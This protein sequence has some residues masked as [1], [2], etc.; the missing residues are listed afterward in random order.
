MIDV[1]HLAGAAP[2]AMI[3]MFALWAAASKR[4]W[5]LRTVVVAAVVLTTLLIPAYELAYQ[6]G[7]ESLLVVAGMAIWRRRRVRASDVATLQAPRRRFSLSL[8]TLMLTVVII[9]VATAV[10]AR[11]PK[12]KPHQW[13]DLLASGVM[14]AVICLTCVWL[15]CGMARWW[16][17]L[18]AAPFLVVALAVAM[19]FLKWGAWIVRH[20]ALSTTA[21]SDFWQGALGDAWQGIV[22]W[23]ISIGL[24]MAVLCTW[25]LLMRSA[26]WFDPF[27]GTIGASADSPIAKRRVALARWA[28][29]ILVCVVSLFPVAFFYR[30]LTPAPIPKVLLPVPNGFDDLVAAGR[31]IGAGAAAKLLAWDKLTQRQLVMELEKNAEAFNRMRRGFQK[32]SLHPYVFEPWRPEDAVALMHLYGALRGRTAFAR[33]SGNLD[34]ELANNL[35]LLRLAHAEK[36][37]IAT[38][39]NNGTIDAF[40]WDA[41]A[42]IWNLRNKLSA[43]QCKSLIA[44]LTELDRRREPWSVRVE[45]QRIIEQN[46][47][48]QD[49]AALIL[50]DWSGKEHNP[51]RIEHFRRVTELRIVTI[52][53]SLRAFQL[54][55]GRWPARLS[56]LVPDYLPGVPQDPFSNSEIKYRLAG[57]SYELYSIGPDEVDDGGKRAVIQNGMYVGDFTPLALF[58]PPVVVNQPATKNSRAESDP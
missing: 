17:R 38:R 35:D 14:L 13:Y 54:D 5:F 55:H 23:I 30:L 21:I 46:K 28:T 48:W 24:G 57:D 58:G 43:E 52:E 8:Q 56:E 49:H 42:G 33:R 22:F 15:A 32:A 31:M 10:I 6:L 27:R 29:V 51:S 16:I 44:Q 2:I 26:A 3:G 40:E 50:E 12:I 34:F 19:Y 4:H 11:T 47:S 9:A 25:M 39:D 18:L 36:R 7:I 45:R 37:G 53:L 1:Y 41:H 20:W